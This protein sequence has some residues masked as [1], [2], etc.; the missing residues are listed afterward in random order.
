M[1]GK[2][3]DN[4]HSSSDSHM[5]KKDSGHA[6]TTFV[7][8]AIRCEWCKVIGDDGSG[9]K[10]VRT[11]DAIQMASD[12]G[13]DLVQISWDSREHMAICKILDYGKFMYEQKRREK[14]VKK[15]A[16][17][18]RVDVKT[19]QFSLTI[20][21]NDKTRLLNQAR[22]FLLAG[23]KVKMTIRFRNRRESAN[24]DLAKSLLRGLL[25]TLTDVAMLDSKVTM[26]G[27]ELSCIIA[28]IRR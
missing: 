11:K 8:Y 28:K 26:S 2:M 4:K 6:K 9:A 21:D 17:V 15:A 19:V 22:E 16:R 1:K 24:I 23:N 3:I 27:R 14:D 13:L 7:N 10:V 5:T 18:N 12:R 20:D 25:D